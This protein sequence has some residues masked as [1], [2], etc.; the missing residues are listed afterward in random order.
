MGGGIVTD[1]EVSLGDK[2]VG[3]TISYAEEVDRGEGID[4]CARGGL[5]I[6]RPVMD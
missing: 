4:S 6:E 3:E 2:P 1:T 5:G